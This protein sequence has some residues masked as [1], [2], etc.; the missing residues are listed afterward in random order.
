[1]APLSIFLWP[2]SHTYITLI[3]TELPMVLIENHRLYARSLLQ[4]SVDS[5]PDPARL[6]FTLM[7]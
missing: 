7:E 1:M 2:R 4:L 5:E 6:S 3:C